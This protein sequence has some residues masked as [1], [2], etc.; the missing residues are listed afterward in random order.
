MR[1]TFISSLISSLG[2]PVEEAKGIFAAALSELI[3]ALD[4]GVS[5]RA[6]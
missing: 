2:R 1:R 5:V 3:A 6:L 4:D